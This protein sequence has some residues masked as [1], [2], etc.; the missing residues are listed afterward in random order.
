VAELVA[1]LVAAAV[2]A[3][4]AGWVVD[5]SEAF[6]SSGLVSTLA[7]VTGRVDG[8]EGSAPGGTTLKT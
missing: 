1:A 6:E 2:G 7:A 8:C 4:A 5:A 3:L